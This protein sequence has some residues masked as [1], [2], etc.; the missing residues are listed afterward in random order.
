MMLSALIHGHQMP[1]TLQEHARYASRV[2][3]FHQF[4][5]FELV[6]LTIFIVHYPVPADA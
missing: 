1:S 3:R 6:K 5:P 2:T 4:I